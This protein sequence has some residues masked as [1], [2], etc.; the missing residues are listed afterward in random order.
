[1]DEIKEQKEKIEAD[2][3]EKDPVKILGD[4]LIN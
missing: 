3:K 1:M 4:Q 2:E